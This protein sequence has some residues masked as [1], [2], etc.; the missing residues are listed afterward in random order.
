MNIMNRV[1]EISFVVLMLM[2]CSCGQKK[3]KT[4]KKYVSVD[5]SYSIEVPSDVVK[6]DCI[7]EFMSF[8]NA[9][10]H[11]IISVQRIKQGRIADFIHEK[12]IKSSDFTYNLIQSSDTTTFFM[13]TRGNNM[14]SA[15]DLYMLKRI[16][17][18]NY[19]I[20][21]NSDHLGKSD[22]IEI[23]NHIY[24]S[25]TQESNQEDAAHSTKDTPATISNVYSNN[26]YSIQYPKGWNVVE[27]LNEMTDVY[28][29]SANE[30][31]GFTI[32]RFETDYP[33]AELYA[34][35]NE[36]I[37]EAGFKITEDKVVTV[38]GLQYYRAIHEANVL[39]Q[40]VKHISYSF[41]NNNMFYNIKFGN[42]TTQA[43]EKLASEIVKSF[44]FI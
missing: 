7:G 25:M 30:D 42:T 12:G 9:Q 27:R 11:L 21:V 10:D 37:R 44:H 33:L 23:I 41:K 26:Y 4:Y 3:A 16:A 28:I 35:G 5:N 6:G 24:T 43:Q 36:N 39:K 14:W 15:Y 32:V 20:N 8:E 13:V 40:K 22:L 34:E 38:N 31:F 2:I 29:G 17:D 18:T 19:I 1:I